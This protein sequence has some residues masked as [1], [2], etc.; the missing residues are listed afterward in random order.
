MKSRYMRTTEGTEGHGREQAVGCPQRSEAHRASWP[1]PSL[2]GRT[3]RLQSCFEDAGDGGRREKTH[4]ATTRPRA[5]PSPPLRGVARRAGGCRPPRHSPAALSV[6]PVFEGGFRGLSAFGGDVAFPAV[7][8]WPQ[9][10]R[11]T[12]ATGDQR[13]PVVTD[14]NVPVPGGGEC[15][16]ATRATVVRPLRGREALSLFHG[17]RC[18]PPVATIVCPPWGQEGDASLEDKSQSGDWRAQERPQVAHNVDA[19]SCR[20]LLGRWRGAKTKEAGSLLYVGGVPG[21]GP[22]EVQRRHGRIDTAFPDGRWGQVFPR[23]H[24]RKGACA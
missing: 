9:R 21:H 15:V 22:V 3:R 7:R 12:I 4:L 23:G 18:A 5:C 2:P 11:T 14:G 20:V 1:L 16:G 17:F 13:E 19:A 6:L 8:F 24:E 10:G